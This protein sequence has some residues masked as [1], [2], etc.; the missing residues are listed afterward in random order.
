MS[1]NTELAGQALTKRRRHSGASLAPA[2]LLCACGNSTTVIERVVPADAGAGGTT[3]G[4]FV[5]IPTVSPDE[6]DL[7][8]FGVVGNRYWLEASEVQVVRMNAPFTTGVRDPYTPLEVGPTFV[9]HLIVTSAG[10]TTQTADFGKIQV[11]LVGNTTGRPWTL[12]TLPNFKLDAD[13][14]VPQNRIGGEEHLRLN[15]AVSGTIFREKLVYD[16][17]HRLGYPAPR[18]SFGWVSGSV[19]GPGVAVPYVVVES[20]KRPFCERH[21]DQL[22]GRC[23]N[24]WEFGFGDLGFP[25]LLED[26]ENCQLR[27]C[28]PGRAVELAG[29]VTSTVPGVGFKEALGAWVDWSAFHRYQCLSWALELADDHL[30]L[31]NVVLVERGDGKFQYLPYSVD[32]SFTEEFGPLSLA[33]GSSLALGCRADPQCWADTIVSCEAVLD[34]LV[35]ISPVTLLDDIR[36]DLDRAGML[37]PGDDESYA[38]LR[39][40]MQLHL[41][42]LPAILEQNRLAPLIGIQCLPPFTECAQ[43]CALPERCD[44]LFP[45]Q[46]VGDAGVASE[47]GP[48]ADAGIPE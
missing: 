13:E 29:L 10:D 1:D 28:D 44:E 7:D 9:D 12:N 6:L 14:F 5:P 18:A 30:R 3:S 46:V 36:N 34:E 16:I 42:E 33:G 24:I 31:T 15:N 11:R 20:Y 35:A 45:P 26:P 2:I 19:W 47:G 48:S 41:D 39:E 43:Y 4:V 37:R 32:V 38:S 17:F 40:H 23:P 8:M 25:G 27:E 22:G 21:A